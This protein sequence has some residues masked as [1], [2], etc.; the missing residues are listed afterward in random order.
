MAT[1]AFPEFCAPVRVTFGAGCRQRLTAALGECGARRP[2]VVAD[3]GVCAAGLVEPIVAELHAAGM[4]PHVFADV[5]ANPDLACVLAAAERGRV[6]NCDSLVAIGG[7]SAMDTAKVAGA[8]LRYGGRPTDY[9]GVDRIPGP[10]PTLICLP[11]TCGTGSEVTANA[12]ITDPRRRF[13]FT[14]RSHHLLPRAAFLDPELL[15]TLPGAVVAA[16]AIDALTHA[17]E[18]YTNRAWQPLCD[19]FAR[20]AIRRIGRSLRAAVAGNPA[21]RAELLLAS[22]MAGIPLHHCGQGLVHAMSAP[23]GGR[24]GVPHGVANAILLPYVTEYNHLENAAAYADV[25]RLLSAKSDADARECAPLLRRLNRDVGI[26][27]GLAALGVD[28][29]ELADLVD[30]TF[31]SRNIPLNPR[32]PE[33]EAVAEL[34]RRAIAGQALAAGR[35]T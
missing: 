1:A 2:L 21:A 14:I 32:P 25:A 22:T 19:A 6:G 13:K 8:L 9:E 31:K 17:I 4:E 12:V 16:T 15:A 3:P 5:I 26:P 7:G 10:L 18:A 23:L 11:T 30:D 33:P 28:E 20:E 34:F 35:C 27:D 29:A 24:Y